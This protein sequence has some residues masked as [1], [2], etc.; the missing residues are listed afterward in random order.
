MSLSRE[1]GAQTGDDAWAF[2]PSD[3]FGGFNDQR[4]FGFERIGDGE[5]IGSRD[6]GFEAG[7]MGKQ[8]FCERLFHGDLPARKIAASRDNCTRKEG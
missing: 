8:A 7:G 3:A 2:E 1:S 6:G 5:F 4:P